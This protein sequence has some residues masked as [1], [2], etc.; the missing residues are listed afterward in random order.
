MKSKSMDDHQVE[1]RDHEGQ[2][3]AFIGLGS[4][5][6]DR[7]GHLQGALRA[8]TGEGLRPCLESSI[9][10]TDPVEV[11]DQGEFLNQVVA[12]ATDRSP[13]DLL[14][15]CLGIERTMGRIRTRERGPRVIDL[16]LLLHG[17]RVMSRGGI[18]LPHPRMH[19]RRFVLIPLVEIA[20]HARHPLLGLT[21]AQ[22]LD[23]CPDRTRVERLIP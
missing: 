8:L 20:P 16:D 7:A 1:T 5:L 10:R 11:V 21:A 3:L 12:C 9:Y 4:N 13:E 2:S 18:D 19:L 22:L 17:D 6:G 15:I 14:A 23:L